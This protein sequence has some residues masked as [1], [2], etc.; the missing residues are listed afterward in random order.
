MNSPAAS[1]REDSIVMDSPDQ[2]AADEDESVLTVAHLSVQFNSRNGP[3]QALDDI[4]LSLRRSEILG[5]V[6]ESGC[7]KSTLG[8]SIMR[9]LPEN[10]Q[11]SGNVH[12]AGRNILTL[13]RGAL[14]AV[15]GKH[16]GMIFQDPMTALNPSMTIGR[17]I[18]EVLQAHTRLDRPAIHERVIELLDLVGIPDPVRRVKDYPHQFSGGMRQRVVIAIALACEPE[19]LIADEPTTAL[20]V[21]VEAQIL[22]LLR[23][24]QERLGVAIVLIS[25]NMRVIR[26]MSQRVMVMYAGRKIEEGPT[27][28][29]LSR[30]RHPYTRRLLEAIPNPGAKQRLKEIPGM[31]PTMRAPA[32]SCSF[33]DRCPHAQPRCFSERPELTG[34]EP[35]WQAACFYPEEY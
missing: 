23:D 20:D 29:V 27:G 11:V 7:G 16:I 25:H 13:S 21:T 35:G 24:L 10:A 12:L 26:R 14:T 18:A 31:V 9:L 3:V 5:I 32:K 15:R 33:A 22:S 19:V 6:G 8:L 2:G 1:S 4:S 34:I 30:P 17:Q 28:Q